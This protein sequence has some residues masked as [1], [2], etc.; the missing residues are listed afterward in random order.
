MVSDAKGELLKS[1]VDPCAKCWKMVMAN[2][3]MVDVQK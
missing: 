1:K 2:G 3:Y